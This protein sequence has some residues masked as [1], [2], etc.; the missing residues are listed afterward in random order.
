MS[1]RVA[2]DL[3]SKRTYADTPGAGAGAGADWM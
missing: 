3:V 1:C 2:R